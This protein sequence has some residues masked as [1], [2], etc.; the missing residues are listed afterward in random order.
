MKVL[1]PWVPR[2]LLR[3]TQEY[4]VKRQMSET[5]A[6]VQRNRD[7]WLSF[8]VRNT[9]R[10]VLIEEP[11][12]S[13]ITHPNA[14]FAVILNQA[15][16]LTPV[17][18]Y[19]HAEDI[20]L[21]KSYVPTAE[22]VSLRKPSWL[23][24]LRMVFSA[25]E[26]F[27]VMYRTRDVLSFSYDGV[28]YGDIVYDSYLWQQQVATV[29]KIDINVLRLIYSCIWRHEC[30]RRLLSSDN[31]EAVLV[32]HQVGI[33][34]GVMLRTALHYGYKGYLRAGHE[35]STLQCFERLDEVYDYEYKP[36]PEDIDAINATLGPEFD[37]VY[38][39][40]FN[41]QVSDEDSADG[42]YAFSPDNK[43][44]SDRKSFVCD[45]GLD[46][47]KRN[48]FVM[49][50][51]FNDHPHSHFRWM[52]FRDYYDWFVQTLSFART[53]SK[54]NWIFKQ[55][56]SIKFYTTKDVSFG[57]LFSNTPKNIVYISENNQIDTRSLV[58][59]ADS[60]ITCEGSAG[61]ELPAMAGIPSVTA[62]DTFY[63][64]LGFALEPRTK[65]QY[66]EILSDVHNIDRLT[67]EQQKKAK[68]AYMHIY[69]FSRVRMSAC[70]ALSLEDQNDSN[71]NNWYWKKVEELYDTCGEVIKDEIRSYID[72]VAKP[73][74]KRL[75]SLPDYR[76]LLQNDLVD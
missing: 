55:H 7:F 25:I 22:Y 51:A 76:K 33:N 23:C 50:H 73:G 8:P 5:R 71:V 62:S 9:D 63:S 26:K 18:L 43:Y 17:W 75:N 32:S 65:K 74:F 37:R 35:Q 28:K 6:F 4:Q 16:S 44:Y 13:Y 11:M 54:V 30:V 52:I 47:K 38:S 24:R 61:F 36:F 15:K 3:L 70:P 45:F 68:T 64:G 48:V 42:R 41:E 40:V 53:F 21:L 66:F 14:I 39:L 27:L 46:G 69:E 60:V 59:C 2:A 56:P 67:P 29:K 12:V 10:K 49:L 20:E 1:L 72:E 57:S 31:F 58:Y 34:S 19:S